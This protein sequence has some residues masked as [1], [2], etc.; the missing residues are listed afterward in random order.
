MLRS[1]IVA[2]WLLSRPNSPQLNLK[3]ERLLDPYGLRSLSCLYAGGVIAVL[4]PEKMKLAESTADAAAYV[5]AVEGSRCA[6][7][8]ATTRD[9]VGLISDAL[10]DVMSDVN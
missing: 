8:G 2:L 7:E 1:Q 4:A 3:Q 5:H 10:S 6:A 9:H